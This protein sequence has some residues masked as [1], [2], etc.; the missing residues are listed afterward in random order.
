VRC[1]C[2]A[3]SDVSKQ[4]VEE[5]VKEVEMMTSLGRHDNVI[6]LIGCA[7]ST[8]GEREL[9]ELIENENTLKQSRQSTRTAHTSAKASPVQVRSPD[10]DSVFS[11]RDPKVYGDF[12][13]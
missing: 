10:P 6:Q 13:V 7:C 11:H 2:V 3:T 8:D 5:L 9:S 12:L 1:D 4:E